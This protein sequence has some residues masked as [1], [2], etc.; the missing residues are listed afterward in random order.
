[1]VKARSEKA[2]EA[3]KQLRE[4]IKTLKDEIE[5]NQQRQGGSL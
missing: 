1:M 3:V 5:R 2:R 4:T